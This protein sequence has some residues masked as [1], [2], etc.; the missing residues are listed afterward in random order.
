M[1]ISPTMLHSFHRENTPFAGSSKISPPMYRCTSIHET[2]R[3][4][5]TTVCPKAIL[6]S[7]SNQKSWPCKCAKLHGQVLWKLLIDAIFH[8]N[9]YKAEEWLEL[10][11]RTLYDKPPILADLKIAGVH[12]ATRKGMLTIAE[13]LQNPP[14]N[15]AGYHQSSQTN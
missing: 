5:H 13:S 1:Q 6:T 8:L 14:Q 3:K 12:T 11:V 9:L 15:A 7:W 10:H 4:H 2:L